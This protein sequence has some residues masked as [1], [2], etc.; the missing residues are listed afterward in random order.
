VIKDVQIVN[1]VALGHVTLLGIASVIETGIIFLPRHLGDAGLRDGVGQQLAGGRLNH[2]QGA[3]LGAARRGAIGHVLAVVR[4]EPPVESDRAVGGHLVGVHQRP[5]FSLKTL[6]HQ[7][8]RLVLRAFAP[9]IK[10][11]GPAN[12]GRP[13]R[14]SRKQL[15]KPLMNAIAP[16]QGIKQAARVSHFLAHILLRVRTVGILQPA[17][18]IGDLVPV[19]GIDD[20]IHLGLGRPRGRSRTG[21]GVVPGPRHPRHQ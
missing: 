19:D 5:V 17:I 15:G 14:A 9:G 2:V 6:P 13:D 8:D 1:V 4:R 12:L 7:Q 20:R 16:G 10:E 3:V 18:G 21:S 11:V